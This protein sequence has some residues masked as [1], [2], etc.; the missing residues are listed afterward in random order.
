MTDD[1]Q[2]ASFNVDHSIGN[3]K[4]FVVH[5]HDSSFKVEVVRFLEKWI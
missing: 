3:N 5:G 4:I 2:Q 1:V